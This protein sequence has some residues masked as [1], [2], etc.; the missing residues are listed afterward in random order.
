MLQQPL[1][2]AAGVS[3]LAFIGVRFVA[4]RL[5]SRLGRLAGR[6]TAT[7]PGQRPG[8]PL[9]ALGA[10]LMPAEAR[11][12]L[13]NRIDRAGLTARLSPEELAACGF[14][15]V[16]LAAA[17]GWAAGPRVSFIPRL[18]LTAGLAY[19][20]AQAPL[21]WVQA[22][23]R[24]RSRAVLSELAGALDLMV[25]CTDGGLA[26]AQ[27]VDLVGARVS[28]PLGHEL[29]RVAR[30]TAAGLPVSQALQALARRVNLGPVSL[31]VGALVRAEEHGTP[32]TG[33][34]RQQASLARAEQRQ[35][36]E[37]EVAALPLKLTLCTVFF[38][39]PTLFVLVVLPNVLWFSRARW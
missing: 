39:F 35:A 16:L 21:A 32:V 8:G 11:R 17:I 2:V 3:L 15:G 28:G 19:L 18:P 1:A 24:A 22:R 20:G 25:A 7:V 29:G 31:A 14:V 27:A 36:F 26:L 23:E 34:L 38:I 10:A 37:R 4:V 9:A 33:T 30:E 6:A 13:A 12:D 5:G